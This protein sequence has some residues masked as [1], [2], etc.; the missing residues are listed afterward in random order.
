MAATY[1]KSRGSRRTA[2]TVEPAPG[3]V[4]VVTRDGN[5]APRVDR[6]AAD[7]PADLARDIADGL[8]RDGY[9]PA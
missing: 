4:I 8:I 5:C 6:L 2:V 9:A 3:T 1:V 7:A